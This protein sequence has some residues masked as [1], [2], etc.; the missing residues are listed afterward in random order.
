MG[1]HYF[2]SRNPRLQWLLL[3]V[4]VAFAVLVVGLG[5]HQLWLHAEYQRKEQQQNQRRIVQ[6]A[7]R[8]R[9]LD[10]HGEVLVGNR[11]R[12]AAVV[13]LDEL[14]T[15]FAR[16]RY[17]MSNEAWERQVAGESAQPLR[18]NWEELLWESRRRV[19][20]RYLNQVQ[21]ILG[22]DRELEVRDLHRHFGRRLLM[23]FPLVDNLPAEDYALLI[24]Q[25]PLGS[26]ISIYTDTTR[27]YP[28]GDLAAHTLGYV[29]PAQ[30]VDASLLPG[31]DLK[32]F[33]FPGSTPRNGLELQFDHLLNGQPGF[34]VCVVDLFQYRFRRVEELCRLPLPGQ[35]LVTTLDARLQRA[36]QEAL[37]GKAGAA[38][39]ID[40]PT[41]EVRVL[42]S[43][44]AYDLNDFSPRLSS[45]TAAEIEQNKAWINRAVQGVYPPG[46]TFKLVT[47]IA[48]LRHEILEP[49]D[50]LRCGTHFTIADRAFPEHSGAS[51]GLVD[52]PTMIQKSSNVYCYQVSQSLGIDRLSA[53][54]RR[55]GLDQPTGIELPHETSRMQVPDREW[56]LAQRGFPW[57]PGDTA[58]VAIGQGD[59]LVSPLQMAAFTASLARGQTR[60][61]VTLRPRVPGASIDHGGEPIGLTF[62]DYAAIIEGMELAAGPRGTARFVQVEGLDIAAKTG[63]AQVKI[64]G[65]KLTLAWI[66]AFAPVDNPQLA[67]AVLVEGQDPNDHFAGGKTAA[68]VARAIFQQAFDPQGHFQAQAAVRF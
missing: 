38:V 64:P 67:V 50:R 63:T 19:L 48:A 34:E 60:T 46:S 51:F 26:Q 32:T 43:A 58:N 33:A 65:R 7:P 66:V 11:P 25:L 47:A 24:E 49:T 29:V 20:Q 6:P 23:P 9:I 45:R 61:D 12:F 14:R 22:G 16:E 39:A 27:V 40:I 44:P 30:E 56:S 28:H 5:W 35:D 31:D 53:E 21:A 4:V 2:N 55:F 68:P 52:L 37:R 17:R 41:G 15:E 54:A 59:L 36:A 3:V 1:V 13:F 57:R 8:G 18:V 42:A 10:Q 62:E